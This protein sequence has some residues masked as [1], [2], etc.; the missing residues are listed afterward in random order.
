MY[1]N[2]FYYTLK[3]FIPRPMRLAVRRWWANRRVE[4]YQGVWPIK[5]SAAVPPI[6]WRGWPDGKKFALVLTHDVEEKAGCDRIRPMYQLEAAL[7]FRSSFNLIP[8]G[9]YSCAKAV[10]DELTSACFEV[11]VH[12]LRHDGKLYRSWAQFSAH[13]KRIN[14]YLTEWNA[15]GFRSGFMLRNLSWL[16]ELNIK[17]DGSTFDTDPFE[18]QPDGADTIFPFWV[19]KAK[20]ENE[21]YIEL[22]YTLP[23]DSTIFRLLQLNSIEIWKRKLD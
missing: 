20:S 3:P 4:A 16:S 14:Q 17:Y 15:V 21:G 9:G 1:L 19:P 11:G 23:Q 5:E 10:R 7:G 6:G 13:A 2:Q 8:E 18:P 22:P 12:D